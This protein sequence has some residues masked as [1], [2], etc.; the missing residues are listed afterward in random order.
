MDVNGDLG[1]L[2]SSSQPGLQSL[3]SNQRLRLSGQPPQRVET[4]ETARFYRHRGQALCFT[5]AVPEDSISYLA[6]DPLQLAD[7]VVDELHLLQRHWQGSGLPLLV[8]PVRRLSSITPPS[9]N[10]AERC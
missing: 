5:A 8:I 6:D 1:I 4:E 9:S 2:P 10:L 7:T 3:G